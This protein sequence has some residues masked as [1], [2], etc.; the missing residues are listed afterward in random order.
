MKIL[1]KTVLLLIVSIK[2]GYKSLPH[3][4]GMTILSKNLG[5]SKL[6]VS[7]LYILAREEKRF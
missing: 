7:R 1:N 3:N 5:V 4:L 6:K 2:Q